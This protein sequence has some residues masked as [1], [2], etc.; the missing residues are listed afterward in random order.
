V[1]VGAAA[2]Y[3][4][5]TPIT[6]ISTVWFLAHTYDELAAFQDQLVDNPRFTAG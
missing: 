3:L 2:D 6:Q 4:A 1:L 5:E